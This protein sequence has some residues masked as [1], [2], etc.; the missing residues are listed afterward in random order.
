[1]NI[2]DSPAKETL[3]VPL[4]QIARIV[5]DHGDSLTKEEINTISEIFDYENLAGGYESYLSDPVKDGLFDSESYEKDKGKYHS[6]WFG[7]F[8]QYPVTYAESFLYNSYGYWYPDIDYWIACGA[9][10]SG[11]NDFGFDMEISERRGYITGEIETL[12]LAHYLPARFPVISMLYSVGFMLWLLLI[13]LAGLIIKRQKR[14]LL[15]FIL[16]GGLWLTVLAS[17]VFAEYRYI[18]GGIVCLP[19]CLAI[20]LESNRDVWP[21]AAAENKAQSR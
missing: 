12:M 3:S 9:A 15:P 10:G 17:P 2:P 14:L 21:D 13:S 16:L 19:V 4:Q 1:M 18:Y 11:G 8:I 7:L 20:A 5:R 6:L